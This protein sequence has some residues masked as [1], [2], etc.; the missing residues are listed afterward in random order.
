MPDGAPRTIAAELPLAVR[1]APTASV[2][3]TAR[4]VDVT[5]ATGTPVRRARW[6]G[7]DTR[8]AFDETL[9]ISRDAIDMTRLAAGAPVLDS[10]SSYSTR[11]QIA[12]VERAWVD[13]DKA[14]AR[15]RFPA[16][17]VDEAADRLWAL[18]E[19]GIVRNVSVGYRIDRVRVVEAQKR[20]EVEQHVVER[21]T[22]Y[23]I[24]FVTVPA[25]PNAQVRSED[26]RPDEGERRYPATILMETTMPDPV[27]TQPDT[28]ATPP[29]TPPVA[30]PATER[31]AAPAPDSAATLRAER[32]RAAQILDI[33]ARAGLPQAD[34]RSAI[35]GDTTVEAFRARAFDALAQRSNG[36][37]G[38]S[39]RVERDEVETRRA[40]MTD[41][42]AIR[43]GARGANGA[44][45]EPNEA[46]RGFMEHSLAELAAESIGHRGRMG[47]TAAREEVIRRAMHT[48]SDFPV[49]LENSLNRALQGRYALQQPSFRRL[50]R[51]RTYVDFRDHISL[52]TG[53]FPDLKPVN[54][55]GEIKA[56]EISD[57]NKEKTS[58]KAYGVQF[59]LSRQ[60]LVN[61]TLGAIAQ[62]LTDH[63]VKVA[64]FEDRTFYAMFLSGTA[65]NGP[66]LI[67]GNAQVF[68][69]ARGNLAASGGALD[70]T[71]VTA[72][73]TAFRNLKRADGEFVDVMPRILL[74]G[75]SRLVS[76]RKL[77]AAVT[78]SNTSEFNPF[79][80][81]FEIVETPRI[82]TNAWYLFASPAELPCFEWGLL[83]GY[84]APRMRID[85]PFG[86]QGVKI[87]LE[88][89]FG[90]GAIDFR[91]GYR[92]PGN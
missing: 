43:L 88:H 33:G 19:Q 22:P 80:G 1:L 21:W 89:D 79:S 71:T 24:S 70:E 63:S 67:E 23:E 74:V 87:S 51:Q 83:E 13:G 20:D 68:A 76:A 60:L 28:P 15:L 59:A 7:W 37:G 54:E 73:R 57:A 5:F 25:D 29:A 66:T 4:T 49:I 35:E 9:E 8:I 3:A 38:S 77:V 84:S 27:R 90:C 26:A 69:A 65:S 11:S 82:T 2:D 40:A 72:A 45:V 92:N 64:Q 39:V 55:A 53:D 61:D 14:A 34:V 44:A 47:S 75:P 81:E 16:A 36:T 46:A 30:P 86:V 62:T 85:E 42:L 31:A 58:V 50:A 41:A 78:P 52:R 17:G 10:H 91:G 56:G 18:V 48:T 32:E 6:V 12:V